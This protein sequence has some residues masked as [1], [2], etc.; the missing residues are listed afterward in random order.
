M[1]IS[2]T[3]KGWISFNRF[4]GPLLVGLLIT[5]ATPV[6][7]QSAESFLNRMKVKFR[8][9]SNIYLEAQ[10]NRIRPD[11]TSSDTMQVT[12]AYAYPDKLLQWVRGEDNREQIMV[13]RGDTL[14]VSYPHIDVTRRRTV[15]RAQLRRMVL[16]QVP[17]AAVFVGMATEAVKP[18]SITVTDSGPVLNVSYRGR[19]R[20][21][22]EVLAQF[23]RET[24]E[25]VSFR[26]RDD[27]GQFH[28]KIREYTE[29]T[30]FPGPIERAINELRPD[31]L[32]EVAR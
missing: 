12:L 3:S 20:N 27:R 15:D 6:F 5:I 31:Y 2:T 32:E 28:V 9:T 17:F 25:P 23:K 18:D 13:F 19:R 22:T 10:S 16:D 29:E 14:V 21:P 24:L 1:S 7:G 4:I 26:I 8:S 30:R 11:G